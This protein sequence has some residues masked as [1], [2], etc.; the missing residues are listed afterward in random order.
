MAEV[1]EI[2]T[3]IILAEVASKKTVSVTEEEEME[4][5]ELEG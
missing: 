3:P 2:I 1:E 4:I 5:L